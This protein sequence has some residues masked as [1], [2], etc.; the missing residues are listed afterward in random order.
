MIAYI[1][2]IC[3]LLS[4]LNLRAQGT[5]PQSAAPI[6]TSDPFTRMI[7][8]RMQKVLEEQNE[9]EMTSSRPAAKVNAQEAAM[10][11]DMEKN[12]GKLTAL[13]AQATSDGGA[14]AA[15][16]KAYDE[17]ES[18]SKK[19]HSTLKYLVP[20]IDTEEARKDPAKS[21]PEESLRPTYEEFAPRFGAVIQ[22]IKHGVIH[23]FEARLVAA[24][25]RAL[26]LTAKERS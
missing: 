25:L 8:D 6:T 17:I 4:P 16:R 19:L 11:L 21:I 14:P 23:V 15:R 26:Q 18:L 10:I 12:L 5:R 22:S 2:V 3:I 7:E 9:R 20:I 13:V 1:C 24:Q